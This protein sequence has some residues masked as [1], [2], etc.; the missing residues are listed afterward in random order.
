[1]EKEELVNPFMNMIPDR[2]WSFLFMA[3]WARAHFPILG[4]SLEQQLL[5]SQDHVS[6]P[7]CWEIL[8]LLT[9]HQKEV[10]NWLGSRLRS[11]PPT[12][13]WKAL[14][15]RRLHL[16]SRDAG[17]TDQPFWL[18]GPKLMGLLGLHGFPFRTP[19]LTISLPPVPHGRTQCHS[20]IS[21]NS[22]CFRTSHL[23]TSTGTQF[24]C[25]QG[26]AFCRLTGCQQKESPE[27]GGYKKQL[28]HINLLFIERLYRKPSGS[29]TRRSLGKASHCA[30]LPR[31]L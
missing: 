24:A 12:P 11:S 1:M 6:I 8:I 29:A 17:G 15:E 10:L 21:L 22:N 13:I 31:N 14:E 25:G 23:K 28:F 18:V 16:L 19:G 27:T 4:I 20:F 30:Q 5:A 3:F 9:E 7:G 2:L 26:Q